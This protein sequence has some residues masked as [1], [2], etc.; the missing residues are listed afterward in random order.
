MIAQYQYLPG[1]PTPLVCHSRAGKTYYAPPWTKTHVDQSTVVVLTAV[2]ARHMSRR[3][4]FIRTTTKE[5]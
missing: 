2:E 1:Q 3:R 5:M 4:W